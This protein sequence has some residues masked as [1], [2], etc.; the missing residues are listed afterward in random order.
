MVKE[1]GQ[2]VVVA[3]DVEQPA[4][5]FDAV[6]AGSRCRSRS[7]P[8]GFPRRPALRQTRPKGRPSPAFVH[9]L[10]DMQ[11]RQPHVGDLFRERVRNHPM[12]SPPP[13]S[14]A[15]AR[16]PIRPTREPPLDEDEISFDDRLREVLGRSGVGRPGPRVRAGENI[17][18]SS[19]ELIRDPTSLSSGPQKLLE[20]APDPA[21]N[22]LICPECRHPGVNPRSQPGGPRIM[23]THTSTA[24]LLPCLALAA[25]GSRSD[26]RPSLGNR[27]TEAASLRTVRNRVGQWP[28]RRHGR[29]EDP[30]QQLNLRSIHRP[31][32][33]VKLT[34]LG[35]EKE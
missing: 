28:R 26:R 12:T 32:K 22:R 3:L 17:A 6:R 18:A 19:R 24:L 30:F 25:C 20:E 14:T 5:A 1:L 9:G 13:S 33:S 7:T 29:P 16:I 35:R 21:H 27:K 11:L 8:P 2:V 15:S 23:I 34:E 4:G 10:D 31:S